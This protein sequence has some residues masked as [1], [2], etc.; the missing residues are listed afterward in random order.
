MYAMV[1]H[2]LFYKLPCHKLF[3]IL[4]YILYRYVTIPQILTQIRDPITAMVYE[5]ECNSKIEF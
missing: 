3:A 4:Q 1:A 2:Q 5:A